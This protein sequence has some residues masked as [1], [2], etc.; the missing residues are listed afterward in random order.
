MN[1]FDILKPKETK[2]VHVRVKQFIRKNF[3][4]VN[5]EGKQV[6][7]KPSKKGR[8]KKLNLIVGPF[9]KEMALNK[10]LFNPQKSMLK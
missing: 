9:P 4:T 1:E 2:D 8:N 6:I 10:A 5:L 7:P 3:R